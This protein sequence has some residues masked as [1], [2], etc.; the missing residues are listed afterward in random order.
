MEADTL[1]TIL[2]S[3]LLSSELKGPI[4]TPAYY[5]QDNNDAEIA[6]DLLMMTHGWRR[7]DIPQV[8]QG[9]YET[10][11]MDFET[12]KQITGTVKRLL[13]GIPVA[14]SEVTIFSFGGAFEI[15]TTDSLGRFDIYG[16]EYPDSVGF[17][18]KVANRKGSESVEL[19][20]DKEIFPQT[21]YAPDSP[22]LMIAESK[23]TNEIP[24]NR[25][26]D[27]LSKAVERAKYDEDIRVIHLSEVV[28]TAQ[29]IER[30]D[31]ARLQ[32]WR[33]R[34]S[35]VTIHRE[36]IQKNV[37]TNPY[38]IFAIVPSVIVEQ[39]EMGERKVSIRGT[40]PL[41]LIDGIPADQIDVDALS[42]DEI[43]AVDVFKSI[44][45]ASVFGLRAGGAAIQITTR[46]GNNDDLDLPRYNFTTINPLGYQVPVEFYSP[47]YDTPESKH[48]SN[49]DYRTTIFW[50]PDITV[51]AS[52]KASFE[53]YTSDF[54]TTYSVVI[55]GISTEG[56]IIRHIDKIEV[57]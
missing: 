30:K 50:K 44:A 33:N 9:K 11:K 5:L 36:W 13:R 41:I 38:H 31:E 32:D 39:T 28:V 25:T 42:I 47:K 7:Y 23:T 57:R 53:F 4:E 18:I 56:K 10:P 16:I 34:V 43:D 21:K 55:E 46:R 22:V 27:F 24:E 2:S 3:L 40:D 37:F 48:L 6:L 8:V 52:G 19:F 26:E 1:T 35:D 49:P 20:V 14:D 51:S 15:V 29:R 54:P 17:M 45:S 12:S